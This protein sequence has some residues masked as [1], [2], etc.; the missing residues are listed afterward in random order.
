MKL[1]LHLHTF[2]S[3]D[4][5]AS[6]DAIIRAVERAGL[7]AIAVTDHNTIRGAVELARVA[8]FP[9]II[10]EEI[11]TLEGEVIG[12]FLQEEIPKRLP[13]EET[14]ARIKVQGGVVAVPHPVDRARRASALGEGALR[15]VIDQVDLIEGRNAR[16]MVPEDNARACAI[17]AEYGLPL[18]AGSDAH[19]PSEIGRCYVE[20]PDFDPADPQGFLAA[21][22]AARLHGTE[23]RAWVKLYSAAARLRKRLPGA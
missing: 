5:S 22:R 2:R 21:M 12:Y 16:C 15:R 4:S 11:R 18:T 3:P 17:A 10:A 20:L 1:D 23:S 19:H 8:P 14:I 13:L 9:V 6:Y 7:D